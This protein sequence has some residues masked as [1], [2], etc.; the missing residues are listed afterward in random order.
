MLAHLLCARHWPQ[1]LGHSGEQSNRAS[2]LEGGD[3]SELTAL[4]RTLVFPTGWA[5]RKTSVRDAQLLVV[6]QPWAQQLV[7]FP[8]FQLLHQYK[9]GVTCS[10]RAPF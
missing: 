5:V 3:L 4:S 2:P 10:C 6:T 7:S 9:L 8:V 1:G